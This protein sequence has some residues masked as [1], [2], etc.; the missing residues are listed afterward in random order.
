MNI[1]KT[2]NDLINTYTTGGE[3]VVPV[4]LLIQ[5][6]AKLQSQQSDL[7]RAQEEACARLRES[8]ETVP[9]DR[10]AD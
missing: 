6:R 10:L 4:D 5:V 9:Y 8:L 7:L 1:E 2:L 3:V